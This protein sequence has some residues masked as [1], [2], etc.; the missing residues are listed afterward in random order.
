LAELNTRHHVQ[1]YVAFS[2]W[3]TFT[4]YKHEDIV[5]TYVIIRDLNKTSYI[6]C[7]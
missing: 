4:W 3:L 6:A 5:D 7:P 2:K 1:V